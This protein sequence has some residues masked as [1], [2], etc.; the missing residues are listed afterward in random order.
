MI[1]IAGKGFLVSQLGA[2][3]RPAARGKRGHAAVPWTVGI[4]HR[5]GDDFIFLAGNALTSCFRNCVIVAGSAFPDLDIVLR[6]LEIFSLRAEYGCLGWKQIY[7]IPVLID[8]FA[9]LAGCPGG[10]IQAFRR[11]SVLAVVEGELIRP[12]ADCQ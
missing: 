11:Q 1:R 10:I 7:G 8:K 2:D 9:A 3:R 12:E 6:A 5:V 4:F